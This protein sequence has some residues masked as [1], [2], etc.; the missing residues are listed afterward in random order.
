MF[1]YWDGYEIDGSDSSFDVVLPESVQSRDFFECFLNM[2]I[3]STTPPPCFEIYKRHVGPHRSGK[4]HKIDR[5]KFMDRLL[6]EEYANM[7]VDINCKHPE[8]LQPEHYAQIYALSEG[9][10]PHEAAYTKA[11]NPCTPPIIQS[12]FYRGGMTV[13]LNIHKIGPDWHWRKD[14]YE[15]PHYKRNLDVFRAAKDGDVAL[16]ITIGPGAYY[17]YAIYIV[18]YMG[19]H[20]PSIAI[21]GGLDCGGGWTD[22]CTYADSIYGYEKVHIPIKY[23][24]R[25]TL[26]WLTEHAIVR[27]YRRYYSKGWEPHHIYT[28]TGFYPAKGWEGINPPANEEEMLTPF[29][30]YVDLVENM[31]NPHPFEQ[32][33]ETAVDIILPTPE[34][35]STKPEIA[36]QLEDIMPKERLRARGNTEWYLSGYMAFTIVDEKPVC[37][38]RVKHNI[39]PY[40]MALLNLADSGMIDFVKQEVYEQRN[41]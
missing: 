40:L 7:S 9:R 24:T 15:G 2:P 11:E 18:E 26:K 6:S 5:K 31:T 13:S 32:V 35:Y 30:K 17:E 3:F 1:L 19:Q 41:E 22:G 8:L 20:F 21:H 37:E 10:D 34:T 12:D 14:E 27:S 29:G 4:T 36:K 23:N 33:L 16:S 38:L 25:H 28:T 39:K